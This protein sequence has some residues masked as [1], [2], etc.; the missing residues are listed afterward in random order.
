MAVSLFSF[1]DLSTQRAADL[2]SL[3]VEGEGGPSISLGVGNEI[4][5]SWLDPTV[6]LI[7]SFFATTSEGIGLVGLKKLKETCTC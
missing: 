5:T 1:F 7:S 4:L 6:N 3:L 2:D